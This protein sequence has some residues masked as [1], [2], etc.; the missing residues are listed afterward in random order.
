W[1]ASKALKPTE[2]AS[3]SEGLLNTYRKLVGPF[4]ATRK[5]AWLLIAITVALF[6]ATASLPVFQLVPLKL[7]PFDNK[8]EIQIL[9]DLPEGSTLEQTA[10]IS[11]KAALIS[12]RLPEVKAIASYVGKPSPIDFNGLVRQYDYRQAPHLAD[13]RLTLAPRQEREHNSHAVLLRLRKLLEPLNVNGTSIKVVEV[14][15]GPPVMST[16]VAEIYGDSLTDYQKQRDAATIVMD[17]LKQEPFVVEVDSS[18]EAE[19]RRWRFQTDKEKAMLSGISTED[20]ALNLNL[21]NKGHIAGY[22]NLEREANPLPITLRLPKEM[23]TSQS[24]L[25][26]L[27]LKGR[28]NST[29]QP[30]IPLGELG[31]FVELPA[32]K[33]IYH[34]NLKPVVYV[35]AE[36][37]GRTPVEVI[38]GIKSDLGNMDI[39]PQDWQSR[40]FFSPGGGAFWEIPE[41]VSIVWDGEGEWDTTIRVFRDMG[42]AFAFALIG[43]F[44]V[45][46]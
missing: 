25:E 13:I 22:F 29:L 14:P 41:D 32:E 2:E 7:L 23:R 44:F 8:D 37:E 9:V 12:G 17:R 4:I 15:P 10:S 35:T 34:K 3:T 39:T 27:P 40:N 30:L 36:L 24:N 20:I 18:V 31:D 33:A 1:L 11:E 26:I 38:M 5:K 42:L 28:S 16:V 43:I 46:R 21:A 19:Q 45:M 6:A